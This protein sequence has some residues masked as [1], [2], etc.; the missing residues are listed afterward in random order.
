MLV[1]FSAA[2]FLDRAVA[3]YADRTG[4]VDEPDQPAESLGDVSYARVG[5]LARAQAAKLDDL[6]IGFGE[7]VAY[8]SHNSAR[9]YNAF[10]GVA[11]HGRVLVP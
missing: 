3:V 11:G 4:I 2:D 5:E 10:F 1:P 9:L 6:G 8:V 7:R